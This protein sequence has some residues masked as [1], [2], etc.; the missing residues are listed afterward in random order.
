M[1]R[2]V[3]CI[4]ATAALSL[5]VASTAA[6]ASNPQSPARRAVL[7]NGPY[8]VVMSK[9][10]IGTSWKASKPYT[11]NEQLTAMMNQL[12]ID[13]LTPIFTNVVTERAGGALSQDRLVVICKN[14]KP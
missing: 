9:P 6:P 14:K 7:R 2:I 11:E 12:A 8:K 4:A 5:L 10:L 3:S 13:G 1:K